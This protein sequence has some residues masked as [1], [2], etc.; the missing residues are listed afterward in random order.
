MINIV[1]LV[2]VL[3]D[4]PELKEFESG[5]KGAFI[6]LRIVKPFKSLDGMYEADF[7]KCIL[8]EGIAQNTCEYCQKGDVI[9]IRGRLAT[10]IEE[11]TL[12]HGDKECKKKVS[13][14]QVIVERVTF[15]STTKRKSIDN[16]APAFQD[17]ESNDN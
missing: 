17:V 7:I 16:Q 1:T 14:L 5:A 11:V 13:N 2:G 12:E 15:I 8:W 9:G 3:Q 4:T 6:T 10:R